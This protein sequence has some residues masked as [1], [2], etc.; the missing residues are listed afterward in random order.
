MRGSSKLPRTSQSSRLCSICAP[1]V[2]DIRGCQKLAAAVIAQALSDLGSHKRHQDAA[3]FLFSTLPGEPRE[4]RRFWIHCTRP[5]ESGDRLDELDE[6]LRNSAR[7]FQDSHKRLAPTFDR[8]R[9]LE[10]SL[11]SPTHESQL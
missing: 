2:W 10:T 8:P 1:R 3:E 5:G 9:G 7:A 6:Q 11:V 4:M